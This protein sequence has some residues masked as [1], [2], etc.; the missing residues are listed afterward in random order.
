MIAAQLCVPVDSD[1]VQLLAIGRPENAAEIFSW[2]DY[3][4]AAHWP[5]AR[6]KQQQLFH[7][8]ALLHQGNLRAVR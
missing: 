2:R 6:W 7:S 4:D 3:G 8:A 5:S 1:E